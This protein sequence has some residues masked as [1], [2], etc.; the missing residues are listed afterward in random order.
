MLLGLSGKSCNLAAML[1]MVG[2]VTALRIFHIS[3][4]GP[5]LLLQ[6]ESGHILD[7]SILL[8]LLW[9]AG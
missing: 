9:S 3:R 6:R 1:L 8:A 2:A 4:L 7:I 5:V